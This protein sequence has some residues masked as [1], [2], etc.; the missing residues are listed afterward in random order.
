MQRTLITMAK[1]RN[2]VDDADGADDDEE[3]KNTNIIEE[4]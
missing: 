1:H 3:E 4:L 2:L